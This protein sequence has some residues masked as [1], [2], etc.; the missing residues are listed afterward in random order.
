MTAAGV[1][2]ILLLRRKER[3]EEE[4]KEKG[5]GEVKWRIMVVAPAGGDGC[6]AFAIFFI[7]IGFVL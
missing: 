2:G 3:E 5:E 1:A 4:R 7:V 6:V